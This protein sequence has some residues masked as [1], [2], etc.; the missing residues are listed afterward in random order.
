MNL[1]RRR[2]RGRGPHGNRGLRHIAASD[3]LPSSPATMQKQTW[4]SRPEAVALDDQ[5]HSGPPG[6]HRLLLQ[7]ARPS[8]TPRRAQGRGWRPPAPCHEEW[9]P[10]SSRR[11]RDRRLHRSR[12]GC[13][14]HHRV[15]R[16][17]FARGRRCDLHA[18]TCR[19]PRPPFEC[20]TP[21]G[22]LDTTHPTSSGPPRRPREGAGA[23]A[24]DQ[25]RPSAAWGR[26]TAAT[27][28]TVQRSKRAHV[29]L[30]SSARRRLTDSPEPNAWRPASSAW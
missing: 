11:S 5:G 27:T 4:S 30:R 16:Q 1:C 29:D 26:D 8:P 9:C 7:D 20:P 18:R 2:V 3:S 22:H 13:G 25:G 15:P 21:R 6:P 19:S 12:P 14:G 24:P 28:G 23:V 10:R 17:R